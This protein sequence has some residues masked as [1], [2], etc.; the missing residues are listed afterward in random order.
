MTQLD[1]IKCAQCGK[2]FAVG[3]EIDKNARADWICPEHGGNKITLE[4]IDFIKD[5]IHVARTDYENQGR[6][7]LRELVQN[8]DDAKATILVLRFERDALYVANDGRAFTTFREKEGK[9]SD[10]EKIRKILKKHKEGD[11]DATGHFGSGFQTVYTFTNA[12]E[13]H[14]GG[15]SLC[16][17]PVKGE[18][19][20]LHVGTPEHLI[21]PYVWRPPEESRGALFK[22]PWRDDSTAMQDDGLGHRPFENPNDFPRWNLGERKILFEDMTGYTRHVLLCCNNL[23]TI[24]LLWVDEG[25]ARAIQVRRME[26]DE[27]Q[28]KAIP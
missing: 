22:L 14:S 12:P 20:F 21:S 9:Q 13:I 25:K 15:G 3:K 7:V 23:Q 10:F 27:G 4:V 11:E 6:M 19:R 24:R 5:R 26:T 17:D 28:A 8:A 18:V 1:Q 16:M 2:P